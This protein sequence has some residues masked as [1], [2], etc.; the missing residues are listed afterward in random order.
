MADRSGDPAF[1]QYRQGAAAVALRIAGAS[2][3]E[4]AE[5]L[6]LSGPGMARTMVESDLANRVT[7]TQRSTLRAEESARLERLLRSVWQKATDPGHAEH[8]P[9]AKV[10]LGII[11][12]HVRLN[13]LDAPA[14][15]VVHTPTTS[16]ID[17]WVASMAASGSA[18]LAALEAPV[19]SALPP[20]PA[21]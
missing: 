2:Y 11:D 19:V 20:A 15:I 3:A 13:G 5:A 14:E 10:A 8:L 6:G 18:D 9:A 4:V 1:Q 21:A 12:R 17:A 7:D 16:E